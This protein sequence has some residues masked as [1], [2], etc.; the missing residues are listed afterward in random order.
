[1]DV[2]REPRNT[3]KYTKEKQIL[4]R[5]RATGYRLGLLINFG[6]YPKL[7]YERIVGLT[8]FFRVF[9]VFRGSLAPLNTQH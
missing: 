9:R 4:E 8:D 2:Q 1:M 5:T 7:E 6:H 3:P